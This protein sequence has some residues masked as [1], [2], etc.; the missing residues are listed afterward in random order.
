MK[1]RNYDIYT[2]YNL[3]GGNVCKL[4]GKYKLNNTIEIR[5]INFKFLVEYILEVYI[6]YFRI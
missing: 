5:D 3:I 4:I 1:N 2:V 6:F